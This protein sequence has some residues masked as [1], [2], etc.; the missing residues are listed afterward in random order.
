MACHVS[1]CM[2]HLMAINMVLFIEGGSNK[3]EN[4]G[5]E[6]KEREEKKR[7]KEKEKGKKERTSR[8]SSNRRRFDG[9]NSSD[10]E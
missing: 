1:T 5:K 8:F 7:E 6:R 3:K 10:R 9:R 2:A 4:E